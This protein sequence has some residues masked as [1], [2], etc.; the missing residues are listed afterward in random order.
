MYVIGGRRIVSCGY[1]SERDA[2][3]CVSEMLEAV[4][5]S[6]SFTSSIILA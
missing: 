1:Y 2:S 5:V 6:N 4:R 3:V